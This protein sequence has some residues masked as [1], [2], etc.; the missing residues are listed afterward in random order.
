VSVAVS[1]SCAQCGTP[2]KPTDQFCGR[3]GASRTGPNHYGA[4]VVDEAFSLWEEIAA[5]LRNATIGE[6]QILRE[7]GRGGMAAVYL[8]H[9]LALNRKVAIKVMAPGILS[10]LGMKDRFQVEAVTVANL[11]H[12]NIVTIHAVRQSAGLHYFV[13]KLIPGSSLEYLI[14]TVRPLPL[15]VIQALAFEVASA[16]QYAHRRGII[17]RD[18]KPSNILMDE[19]GCAVVTDFGIARVI[20]SPGNTPTGSTVGTPAYMSPEQC[21]SKEVTAA[22]DQYSLG[23]VLYEMLTGRPPFTGPTLGILRAHIEDQPDPISARRPDCPTPVADAVHRMLAKDSAARWPSVMAAV[24]ALGGRPVSESDPLKETLIQLSQGGSHV[25]A[26]EIRTPRSPI[27]VRRSEPK[28]N[29]R[30]ESPPQAKP[31]EDEIRVRVRPQ[32]APGPVEAGS[33]GPPIPGPSRI[34][35]VLTR[36]S[37]LLTRL[38]RRRVIT[39]AGAGGVIVVALALLWPKTDEPRVGSVVVSPA[40]ASVKVGDSLRLSVRLADSAGRVLSGREVTWSAGD[41]SYASVSSA[42]IVLGRSP[43]RTL[44][45]ASA[46]GATGIASVTVVPRTVPV[47]RVEL[48]DPPSPIEVGDRFTL[49][50]T[51]RDAGGGAISGQGVVWSSTRAQVVTVSQ[52]GDVVAVAPGQ[53]T[54]TAAV[55]DRVASVTITVVDLRV[56]QVRVTPPSVVVAVGDS[57]RLRALAISSQGHPVGGVVIWENT[58][59]AIAEVTSRGVVI[60]IVPGTARIVATSG[61]VRG[62]AVVTVVPNRR[63]PAGIS[64]LRLLVSPWA[65]LTIDGVRRG[66]R[67]RGVDTVTAGVRH[68]LRFEREGFQTVDTSV[69]LRAGE[70]RLLRIQMIRRAP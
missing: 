32:P 34:D 13:M 42:G 7:L 38:P 50:V 70:Q 44:I 60:G 31:S 4:T 2:F 43:G 1:V 3:C 36:L 29:P 48:S 53:A 62:S 45:R 5:R 12:P 24:E 35:E 11:N 67:T 54:I 6:F 17:H 9:D 52:G 68:A 20:E 51:A 58:N 16:L 64:I 41:G 22:S 33:A 61:G 21:W 27:P 37:P 39:A 28:I 47:A 66:Q 56:S 55:G 57:S 19:N 23:V 40:V 46:D 15:P 30:P 8:A 18:V 49:A 63:E 69:T 14:K 65:N 25:T 26:E 10:G 59:G